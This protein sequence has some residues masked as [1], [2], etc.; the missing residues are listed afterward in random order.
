M[1]KLRGFKIEIFAADGNPQGLRLI[2]KSNWI[3][4]GIV[5]PRGSY[6]QAKKRDEFSRS[7]VYMLIGHDGD[8]LPMLYVGESEQVVKRLDSH[9][10]DKDFWQ[11]AIIFTT[12]G[13]QY[14]LNKAQVKYLESRLLEF[15]KKAGR[16]ELQ[17]KGTPKS[18]LKE[19]D[20]AVLENYLDELLSLLPL[21]GV[22]FLEL[23]DLSEND[24]HLYF[25][26]GK[27][28]NAKGL[29]ENMGFRVLKGSIARAEVRPSM[30]KHVR[31]YFNAYSG[32]LG[33]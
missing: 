19:A 2:E 23:D 9:Y 17:N 6:P 25:C 11:Q 7:G 22:P 26:K 5:C 20:R 18:L 8:S 13:D 10:T 30:K 24:R 14:Q 27:G 15:A 33:Q 4:L 12:N 16:S 3:G 21:L 1:S 31:S 32:Q 29:E 28:Y